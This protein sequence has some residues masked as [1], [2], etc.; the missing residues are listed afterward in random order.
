MNL[1]HVVPELL[2]ARKQIQA[3]H[4][5]LSLQFCTRHFV[6]LRVIRN[7]KVTFVLN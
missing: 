2:S 5:V 3:L 1:S 6:L 7:D 4:R